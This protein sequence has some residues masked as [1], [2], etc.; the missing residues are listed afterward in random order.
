MS[1]AKKAK[2]C[3]EPTRSPF[4]RLLS[5]S[6]TSSVPAARPGASGTGRSMNGTNNTQQAASRTPWRSK[7]SSTPSHTPTHSGSTRRDGRGCET[8]TGTHTPSRLLISPKPRK[9]S[10]PTSR[11]AKRRTR[12]ASRKRGA[13]AT[14]FMLPTTSSVWTARRSAYPRSATSL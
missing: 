6:T 11:L 14:A 9:D 1:N 12:R 3:N 8:F 10:S 13:A 5:K 2:R 7:S 4:V